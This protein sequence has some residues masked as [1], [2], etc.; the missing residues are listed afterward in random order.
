[1]TIPKITTARRATLRSR[2]PIFYYSL[3]V[4][5]GAFALMIASV[6]VAGTVEAVV[7]S[8]SGNQIVIEK[9]GS[10]YQDCT[11]FAQA[12][13]FAVDVCESLDPHSTI[14]RTNC[15]A[16]VAQGEAPVDCPTATR[17]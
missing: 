12:R 16:E 3:A 7:G 13:G 8:H 9:T 2:H 15:A 5:V 4:V 17:R 14:A 1:M 6:I 11:A 10:M